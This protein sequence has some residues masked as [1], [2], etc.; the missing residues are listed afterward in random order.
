VG[1]KVT[2]AENGNEA[3]APR[4]LNGTVAN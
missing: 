3:I 4:L 2:V 1:F